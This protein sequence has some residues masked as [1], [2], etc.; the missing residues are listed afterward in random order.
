MV[1]R[2]PILMKRAYGGLMPLSPMDSAGLDSMPYEKA[3]RVRV[4]R[5]RSQPSNRLYW[6][7]LKLVADNLPNDVK[8]WH[9]HELLKLQFGVSVEFNLK[10]KGRVVIPG[11]TSF[12]SMSE[13][14]WREFLPQ[15][16]DFLTQEVLPG[17]GKEDVLAM[18]REMVGQ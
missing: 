15:V 2:A 5:A 18:A 6:S 10:T 3:L 11:S 12:E 16:L 17:L 1:D 14:E 4:T 13:A 8:D 7:V 9:L